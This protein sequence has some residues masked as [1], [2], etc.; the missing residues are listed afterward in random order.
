MSDQEEEV[1]NQSILLLPVREQPL[2]HRSA[3]NHSG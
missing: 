1:R 3:R 2:L